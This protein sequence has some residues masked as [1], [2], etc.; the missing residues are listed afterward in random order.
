MSLSLVSEL[1]ANSHFDKNG[2]NFSACATYA[3]R[4]ALSMST[5]RHAVSGNQCCPS[6]EQLHSFTRAESAL[7]AMSVT[8]HRG[9]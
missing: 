8:C 7:S 2:A 5:A 1:S 6:S 4:A 3:R 9:P